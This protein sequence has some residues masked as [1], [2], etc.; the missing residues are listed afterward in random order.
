MRRV[1][2]AE[3]LQNKNAASISASKGRSVI[4]AV[5]S[6]SKMLLM[7]PPTGPGDIIDAPVAECEPY[8]RQ[9]LTL[10]GAVPS[11]LAC[12]PPRKSAVARWA[13]ARVKGRRYSFKQGKFYG[14]KPGS[15]NYQGPGVDPG[16]GFH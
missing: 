16:V 3:P 6:G 7:L 4:C 5:D 8:R 12:A 11:M 13:T 9:L 2:G 14:Q 1:R 10:V 15:A